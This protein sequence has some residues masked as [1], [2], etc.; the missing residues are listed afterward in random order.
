MSA[1][2][3]PE[4]RPVWAVREWRGAPGL[5]RDGEPVTPMVFW[6]WKPEPYEVEHFS[7]AGLSLFSFFGSTQHYDHRQR[8]QPL[9]LES[10]PA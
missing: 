1:V 6:Q 9:F 5:W 4:E 2:E 3:R 8:V 10:V 7:A